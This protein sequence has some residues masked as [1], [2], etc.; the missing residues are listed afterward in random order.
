MNL[1]GSE[2]FSISLVEEVTEEEKLELREIY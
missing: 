1:H 2:K